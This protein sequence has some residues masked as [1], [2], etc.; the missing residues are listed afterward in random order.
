MSDL[1]P[2]TEKSWQLIE[3][4]I[5]EN[6]RNQRNQQRWSLFFRL[7]FFV[8]V[9]LVLWLVWPES[10]SEGSADS[11]KAV[12]Q[13]SIDGLIAA[14]RN[15]NAEDLIYALDD[16]FD[17]KSKLILLKINSPGGSP[18]QAGQ[19]Y[20]EIRRL[21]D[22]HPK[23][24]VVAVITDVGASGAYYIA[25]AADS[26][27]ADPAS[28][29]GSIGVIMEGF[30]LEGTL[31]KLGAE[32]R[33]LTAGN[34][35]DMLDPFQPVDPAHEKLVRAMLDDIHSQ[36]IDAVKQGRGERLEVKGHPELFSGLFWT[37]DQALQLGLIDGLGSPLSVAR[38]LAGSDDIVDYTYYPTRFERLMQKFGASI[39]QSAMASLGLASE[40]PRLR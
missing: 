6:T 38:E 25:A 34:N 3:K 23:K 2:R 8:Y 13:I 20:R 7:L 28:I 24:K 17:S 36:F 32:R 21:K 4:L 33:V 9:G 16:A 30:G 11:S 31:K 5:L 40:S 22:L 19:V 29:V 26:I 27:Y 14:D 1:D 15:A 35:K 18:V 37:G 12:A 10:G 39:G